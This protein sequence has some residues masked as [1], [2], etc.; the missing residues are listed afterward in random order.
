MNIPI[1]SKIFENLAGGPVVQN[2]NYN[3]TISYPNQHNPPV[4]NNNQQP[5][6]LQND[7]SQV[8]STLK[9]NK[10]FFSMLQ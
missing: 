8:I 1:L 5:S 3:K 4:Q 2:N 9:I 10:I 7:Q 6:N